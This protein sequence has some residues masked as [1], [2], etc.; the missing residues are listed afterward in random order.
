MYARDVD[1]GDDDV[2]LR[3]APDGLGLAGQ[4]EGAVVGDVVDIS[5]ARLVVLVVVVFHVLVDGSGLVVVAAGGCGCWRRSGSGLLVAVARLRG[6]RAGRTA[7]G[8]D[9]V[10][11]VLFLTQLLNQRGGHHL[12]DD[13]ELA[14]AQIIVDDEA[15]KGLAVHDEALLSGFGGK[16]GFGLASQSGVVA[17]KA[18][19][20][21]GVDEHGIKR[22]SV[23]L[24]CADHLLT[25]HL[26]LGLLGNLHGRQRGRAHAIGGAFHG[27]FHLAL[28]F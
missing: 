5:L 6:G 15:H 27:V 11:G 17:Q 12:G 19:V 21:V 10:A 7:A 24:A 13:V 9:A 2:V 8:T 28:E 4:R 3:L 26:L 14:V 18:A 20:I 22:G 25:A 23:L 16:V 1:V